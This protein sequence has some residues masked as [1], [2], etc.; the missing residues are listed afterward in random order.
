L[1]IGVNHILALRGDFPKGWAETRGVFDYANELFSCGLCVTMDDEDIATV[2]V[3]TI[4]A[5]DETAAQ[6]AAAECPVSAITIEEA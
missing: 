6:E 2:K 3:E 5:M 4:N 1:D